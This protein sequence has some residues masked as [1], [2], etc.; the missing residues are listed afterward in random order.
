MTHDHEIAMLFGIVILAFALRLYKLSTPL[1]DWHSFRQADTASVAREYLKHGLDLMQPRY[2]DLSNIQSG[3]ANPNGYR[4]VEFPII[5]GLVAVTYPIINSISHLDLH[6]WYRLTSVFFSLGS[7]VLLYLI[8]KRLFSIPVA[9]Y[10]ALSFA[11]LP[12]NIFYSRSIFPE[13]PMVTFYLL[14]LYAALHLK[15]KPHYLWFTLMTLSGALSLLLKPMAVF[16]LAPL[17]IP[18]FLAIKKS[19]RQLLPWMISLVL[20]GL[21]L[22]FWRQW[23]TQFPAGIP[24]SDWLLNGNGIRFRPAWFRWLFYE[25]LTKLILGYAGLF[26]FSSGLY[27]WF[28]NR[29]SRLAFWFIL[30]WG[31]GALLYLIT[32]AT[33][34]VQHDYYQVPLIPLVALI[35]GLGFSFLFDQKGLFFKFMALISLVIM[36]ASAWYLVSGYYKINHWAIVKAGQA[37]D[38]LTPPEALVIAPYM[39]D[40]AFLYQTNRRGWPLGF[41]LDKKIA[42]GAKFYVSVNYDDEA[43]KLEEKYP[44]LAKTPDYILIDLSP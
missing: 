24:A 38:R 44:V 11:I 7:L 23:I 8:T 43:R 22:L 2:H 36:L 25:R 18:A 41:D 26:I 33:G 20:M 42:Q 37:V 30:I 39:G 13:I 32:F 4:M 14:A 16:M 29:R 3:Q 10:T 21:P 12:F 34:N 1:A 9:K 40:T 6:V 17:M 31:L 35:I 19:H 28:K 5:S 15:D 27:A